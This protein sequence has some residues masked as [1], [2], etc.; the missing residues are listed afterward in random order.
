[1]ARY[2]A[3]CAILSRTKA[4]AAFG[5]LGGVTEGEF[6]VTNLASNEPQPSEL[7]WDSDGVRRRHVNS[8]E[9]AATRW[10][11]AAFNLSQVDPDL[12]YEALAVSRVLHAL[13]A[14]VETGNAGILRALE[15]EAR[16]QAVG[17]LA[18]ETTAM[19]QREGRDA[20]K[21]SATFRHVN[22]R[23]QAMLDGYCDS[24]HRTL[25]E[26]LE[27]AKGALAWAAKA[28][29]SGAKE[30][31]SN[32]DIELLLVETMS[33]Q[34]ATLLGTGW[35]CDLIGRKRFEFTDARLELIEAMSKE[36]GRTEFTSLQDL[37]DAMTETAIRTLGG[38]ECLKRVKAGEYQKKSRD[39]KKRRS[40]SRG[41]ARDAEESA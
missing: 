35:Y 6:R 11:S 5:A 32:E 38:P 40:A 31:L 41:K 21:V 26:G 29:V 25:K 9:L 37:A 23:W 39:H 24:E 16:R 4:P 15:A 22:G 13:L 20:W 7:S 27:R 34:A 18:A 14:G 33:S 12:H 19:L 2:C 8:L 36:M 17:G 1:M 28:V 30:G 10:D 3:F